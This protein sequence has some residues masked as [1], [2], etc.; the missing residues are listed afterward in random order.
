MI[1][2]AIILAGGLGTRLKSVVADLPK[3]L[4]PVAGKP[5]LAYLLDYACQQ[6]IEKFIFALGYKTEQIEAFV[7]E[8]LPAGSY[9]FSIEDQPLGTGGAIYKACSRISGVHSIVLNAD[10]FFAAPFSSLAEM[11]YDHQAL[12]VLALKPMTEFDRYG[13]VSISPEHTITGFSEKKWQPKG[14][15]NGGVYALSVQRFLKKS[16]PLI[17][18]F[19]KDYLEKEFERDKILAMVSDSYFIDIGIPEDYQRAQYELPGAFSRSIGA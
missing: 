7:K 1:R 14:L 16:F 12:C 15:I 9:I 3:S 2:E 17:F 18:S 10:T 6:G 11:Q 13:V 19:E 8:Y 5:F 4:A